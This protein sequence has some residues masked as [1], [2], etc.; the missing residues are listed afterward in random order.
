VGEWKAPL[1]LRVSNELRSELE[2]NR[3]ARKADSRQ[4]WCCSCGMGNRAI[5]GYGND[6]PLLKVG[7]A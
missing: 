1:S 2:A 5:A 6:R 4:R 7:T 3:R